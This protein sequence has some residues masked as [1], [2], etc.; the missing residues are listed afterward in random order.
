MQRAICK[1]TTII[2]SI[3]QSNQF[4]S[5]TLKSQSH[6]HSRLYNICPYAL[7]SCRKKLA[8]LKK[9]QPLKK[10]MEE[11][12][13]LREAPESIRGLLA[14]N[15]RHA[16]SR[17]TCHVADRYNSQ[18]GGQTRVLELRGLPWGL[19][20]WVD[21]RWCKLLSP[22]VPIT[23]C[24]SLRSSGMFGSE[25]A[26]RLL[27]THDPQ[28]ARNLLARKSRFYTDDLHVCVI[29]V[30]TDAFLM[31]SFIITNTKLYTIWEKCISVTVK[32]LCLVF[33]CFFPP[34]PYVIVA[35]PG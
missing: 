8:I 6:C 32:Y 14:I 3:D 15:N 23:S 1:T 11:I 33:F 12:T 21:F 27:T 13:I 26:S 34:Q 9:K 4:Y 35:P 10:T 25:K 29:Q 28:P 20:L 31:F 17:S 16:S 2:K 5:Y 30:L 24:L 7:D 19:C 18:S 22:Q